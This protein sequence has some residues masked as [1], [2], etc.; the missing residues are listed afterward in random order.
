MATTE[1]VLLG[2]VLVVL[3][4]LVVLVWRVSRSVGDSDVSTEALSAAMSKSWRDLELN[5]SVSEVAS[6]A[7]KMRELHAD[8]NQLLQH[9]QDRG[10]FG[11][12]QLDILLSDHLPPEMYGIREQVV[13]GKTPDAH[14]QS[15]AGVI[16]ID[17]KF[18]L[19][20]YEQYLD[21]DE[22]Q[23]R[24]Q[25]RRKFRRDVEGQLEKIAGDYVRP[26]AGTAEFAFAFI[27]SESV[28]YHLVS[29]E[30][31]LLNE[32]TKQ[33][34]QVVSPLT[35]GH[36]LELI[37]ADVHAQ[38]LSEEATE[39]RERLQRLGTAFESFADDWETLSRHISNAEGKAEDVD[40]QFSTLRTEFD[41]IEQP[42]IDD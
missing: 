34:V 5:R 32:Y 22:D 36:K 41:R 13:D 38:Q 7:E 11:E 20:N 33:G 4:I 39:I 37:K 9:P 14:I 6:H 31:D 16:C 30:Y 42:S 35:L 28:Y 15:S 23:D 18:P 21:A 2:A 12:Q 3:G 17:S 1:T 25:Y 10:A 40:R 8:I 27:P 19:D 26:E 24:D 29:E